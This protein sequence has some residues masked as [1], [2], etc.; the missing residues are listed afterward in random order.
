MY[1]RELL[2]LYYPWR[3]EERDLNMD[4]L[5]NYILHSETIQ[6]KVVEY[7]PSS[8]NVDL[9]DV[10]EL[11]YDKEDKLSEFKYDDVENN[12]VGPTDH[13]LFDDIQ[14]TTQRRFLLPG[15][16]PQAEYEDLMESLNTKQKNYVLH[17]VHSIKAKT[18]MLEYLGGGAG[19]GKST[20]VRAVV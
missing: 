14:D 12:G 10:L 5:S 20:T 2:M 1:H 3:N 8:N 7:N 17:V 11:D 4:P 19:V 15:L 18:Q 6:A 13:C 9:E 16:L